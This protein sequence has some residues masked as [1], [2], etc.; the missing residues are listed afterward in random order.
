MRSL[1]ILSRRALIATP[2]VVALSEAVAAKPKKRKNN[3]DKRKNRPRAAGNSSAAG[4]LRLV[5]GYE[6][7]PAGGAPNYNKVR[8][9]PAAFVAGTKLGDGR[10]ENLQVTDPG[11]YAGW[12]FIESGYNYG[13]NL[14]GNGER[15][16][17]VWLARDATVAVVVR[18]GNPHATCFA[19]GWQAGGTVNLGGQN[20]P[21]YTR[22]GNAGETITV[23]AVNHG[24]GSGVRDTPVVLIGNH[25]GTAPDPAHDRANKSCQGNNETLGPDLPHPDGWHRQ[26]DPEHWCYHRHEHGVDPKLFHPAWNRTF[27]EPATAAGMNESHVG[28]KIAVAEHPSLGTNEGK[29]YRWLFIHHI[30]S[31][32][33]ARVCE[34]YHS[35]GVG[36]MD[37]DSG[38]LLMDFYAML[39]TG[40]S[41][42][43][44]Q[45]TMYANSC[46][47]NPN[48][49]YAIGPSR[50]IPDDQGNPGYE[51]WTFGFEGL[52]VPL[53]NTWLVNTWAPQSRCRRVNG[54]CTE[55][56]QNP[57]SGVG[58]FLQCSRFGPHFAGWTAQQFAN[59]FGGG[60]FCT[61][62]FG[63]NPSSVSL[64]GGCPAGKVK[65]YVSPALI[66]KDIKIGANRVQETNA[67]GF[68]RMMEASTGTEQRYVAHRE[69][70]IRNDAQHWDKN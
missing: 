28:H 52:A 60:H 2:V 16:F 4:D 9:R 49:P 7:I 42:E 62:P 44:D 15:F 34:R 41:V 46:N 24:A 47:A 55:L 21:V 32:G 10:W 20:Y 50:K 29:V 58:R 25:N 6:W 53:F 19:S 54:E 48:P 36:L 5:D 63:K 22:H 70:S 67:G 31:G 8:Y 45:G 35:W 64:A 69:Y 27:G 37:P 3:H 26:I 18:S 61:D 57:D 43:N 30:G 12:D 13:L 17:D 39:D 14:S 59:S 1:A 65:Q 66:G 33:F 56:L 23:C 40:P 38:D 11:A 51:P 68:G